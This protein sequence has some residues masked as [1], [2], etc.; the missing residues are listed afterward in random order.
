M[1]FAQ[2][3]DPEVVTLFPGV[4][5]RDIIEHM[6][7]IYSTIRD[8]PYNE[9]VET[10]EGIPTTLSACHKYCDTTWLQFDDRSCYLTR[11]KAP[12]LAAKRLLL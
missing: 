12:K 9:A 5:D 7:L 10:H 3:W 4:I 8:K 1:I 6:H 2:L 11:R